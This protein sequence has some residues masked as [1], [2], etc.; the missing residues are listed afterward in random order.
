MTFRYE[1]TRVPFQLQLYAISRALFA[2]RK[3]PFAN[4]YHLTFTLSE[5]NLN[6]EDLWYFSVYLLQNQLI[7]MS[8]ILSNSFKSYHLS[9]F[10]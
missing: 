4:A 7:S 6:F 1:S 5:I 2:N 3:I 9:S 8:L 10:P